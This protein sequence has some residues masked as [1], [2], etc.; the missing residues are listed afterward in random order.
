MSPLINFGCLYSGFNV[1]RR[2]AHRN[3]DTRYYH[4][5]DGIYRIQNSHVPRVES[6]FAL[7]MLENHHS[8]FILHS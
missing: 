4:F 6:I 2:H 7:G 8:V 1:Q 3:N 5:L